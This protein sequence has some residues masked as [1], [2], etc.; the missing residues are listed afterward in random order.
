[1]DQYFVGTNQRP[2]YYNPATWIDG[3]GD[4]IFIPK[5]NYK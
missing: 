3:G 1:M 2:H 4:L 5:K